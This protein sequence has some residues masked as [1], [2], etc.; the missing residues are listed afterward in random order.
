MEDVSS[1]PLPRRNKH[2]HLAP[3]SSSRVT[4]SRL[5][6]SLFK[7]I[8][9]EHART[10]THTRTQATHGCV[11]QTR[12]YVS[13]SCV[14]VCVCVRA[15]VR[16]SLIVGRLALLIHVTRMSVCMC[17]GAWVWVCMCLY[18]CLCACV[19]ATHNWTARSSD[20]YQ[21]DAFSDTYQGDAL[22]AHHILC[23]TLTLT[24]HIFRWCG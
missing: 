12:V 20:T 8:S 7:Y 24:A 19:C 14:C 4:D 23:S 2:A 6:G 15:C 1:P 17:V 13:H 10:H 11:S 16:A 22:C 21:G 9:H 5:G 3:C 18:V